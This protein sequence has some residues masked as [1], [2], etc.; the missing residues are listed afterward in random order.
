MSSD[1]AES[2]TIIE[3]DLSGLKAHKQAWGQRN[4]LVV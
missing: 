4:Y 1:D 3:D 2:A